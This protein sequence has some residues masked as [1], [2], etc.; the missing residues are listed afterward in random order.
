MLAEGALRLHEGD[1]V[2]VLRY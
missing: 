1:L 2:E